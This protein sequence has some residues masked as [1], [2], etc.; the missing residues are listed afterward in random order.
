MTYD[1]SKLHAKKQHYDENK[2]LTSAKNVVQIKSLEVFSEQKLHE[3]LDRIYHLPRGFAVSELIGKWKRSGIVVEVAENS[4]TSNLNYSFTST[5]ETVETSNKRRQEGSQGGT[6]SRRRLNGFRADRLAPT[7]GK[8]VLLLGEGDFSFALSL[9]K[10]VETK[11]LSRI[12][13]TSYD[14]ESTVKEKYPDS[15]EKNI[16]DL[17]NTG[18]QV[19]HGVDAKNV[20]S[21]LGGKFTAIVFNFPF[22]PSPHGDPKPTIEM[23][24][25]FFASIDASLDKGD[26]IFIT[27]K[28]YWHSRFHTT[29]LAEEAGFTQSEELPFKAQAFPGYT[30]KQTHQNK[31]PG[32]TEQSSTTLVYKKN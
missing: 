17:K 26:E 20:S 18:V 21:S 13:A 2:A 16:N 32:N 27:T 28:Q 22:V 11:Q 9:A 7:Q 1:A 19:L 4:G 6:S 30:H 5:S 14:N 23:L 31:S 3:I 10:Q 8:K 25:G 12:T 15:G 24:K 29:K